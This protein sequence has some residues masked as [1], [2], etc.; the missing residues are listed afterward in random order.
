[1]H[2]ATGMDCMQK[3]IYNMTYSCHIKDSKLY[4]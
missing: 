2:T 4:L 3:K 1:M